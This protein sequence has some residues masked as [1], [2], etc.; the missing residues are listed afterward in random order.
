MI[1]VNIRMTRELEPRLD[2][3]ARNY[4]RSRVASVRCC[5]RSLNP[6]TV[7]KTKEIKIPTES[8]LEIV[9][10]ELSDQWSN[11]D[12]KFIRFAIG[13]ELISIPYL[14]KTEKKWIAS[15]CGIDQYQENINYLKYRSGDCD[16]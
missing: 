15:R 3:K 16:E 11:V 1:E 13:L 2:V 10:L 4:S 6:V 14:S 7:R 8:S 9:S 12:Y 5:L